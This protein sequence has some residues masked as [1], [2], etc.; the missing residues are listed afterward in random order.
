MPDGIH[1]NARRYSEK[2]PT[3]IIPDDHITIY[4][5]SERTIVPVADEKPQ[6]FTLCAYQ[7]PLK[8][9]L[10]GKD[11]QRSICK[12]RSR[13]NLEST[14]NNPYVLRASSKELTRAYTRCVCI[15]D[16]M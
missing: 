12:D 7:Q 14:L 3:R 9:K 6:T 10:Y 5:P 11:V 4:F 1:I 16:L 8:C 13:G 15:P 2:C